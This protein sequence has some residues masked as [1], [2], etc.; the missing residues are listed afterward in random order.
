MSCRD[1]KEEEEQ[2]QKG[3]VRPPISKATM[4]RLETVLAHLNTGKGKDQKE[5]HD[6]GAEDD[7]GKCSHQQRCMGDI[8]DLGKSQPGCSRDQRDACRTRRVST[9]NSSSTPSKNGEFHQRQTVGQHKRISSTDVGDSS[10]S[11]L[12]NPERFI[13]TR[14]PLLEASTLPPEAYS[15]ELW[16]KREMERVFVPSWTIL[17]RV[18]EMREPGSY[19]AIDSEWGGPV[20]ACRGEDGNIYA[21]ANV[22]CHRGAKVVPG[23][24]GRGSEIGLVCPYH[25]WTYDYNGKLKW[26]PGMDASHNFDEDQIRLTP[27]RVETFKGFVFVN[28]SDHDDGSVLSLR[29][30][31]GDLPQQ[32]PAWFGDGPGEGAADGMVCVARREFDVPCNWKFLMENT[33]ETYH[34]S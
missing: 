11:W 4:R 30:S 2:E 28:V 9:S 17:G 20:A 12:F 16:Y 15:S 7:S 27:V 3:D 18:D 10:P 29:E 26:A 25:A 34:T 23:N 21:F 32:M 6:S 22:C 1:T 24:K 14:K 13:Q 31:L 19:L 5:C 8:E 33:C